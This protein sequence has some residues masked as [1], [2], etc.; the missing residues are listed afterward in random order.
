MKLGDFYKNHQIWRHILF[1]HPTC[2]WW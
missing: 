1:A 2:V